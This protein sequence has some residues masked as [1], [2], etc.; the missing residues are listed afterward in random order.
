MKLFM[1]FILIE[2]G[3]RTY[4]TRMGWIKTLAYNDEIN[5]CKWVLGETML[6]FG[7]EL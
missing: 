5:V 4:L 2:D 7:C 1:Q 3:S 6:V